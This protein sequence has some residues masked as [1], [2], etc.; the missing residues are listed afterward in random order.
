[1]R[2]FFYFFILSLVV[3]DIFLFAVSSDLRILG[4][5]ILYVVFVKTLKL[6]SSVALAL[7]LTLLIFAYVQ[8]IFSSSVVFITPGSPLAE[9]TAVWVFLFLVAGIIQKWRE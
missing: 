6:K 3:G 4:I 8:F 7:A 1:M 9:K 5:L 2:K